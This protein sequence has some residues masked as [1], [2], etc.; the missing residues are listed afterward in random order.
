MADPARASAPADKPLAQPAQLELVAALVGPALREPEQLFLRILEV[1]KDRVESI[2]AGQRTVVEEL[3]A[4]QKSMPMQRKP[5]SPRTMALHLHVI[6]TRRNG[7]C[8]CCQTVSVCD[9][10]GRLPGA[11]FDHFF[12]RNKPGATAT[13]CVCRACNARLV[14]TDFKAAARSAFEAYQAALRPLLSRQ[15][16]MNFT[17]TGT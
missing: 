4:L 15:L 16:P 13:W 2:H 1:V 6:L 12:A 5:L 8:P 9:A 17:A 14:D 11:E 10:N 3:R 7:Y